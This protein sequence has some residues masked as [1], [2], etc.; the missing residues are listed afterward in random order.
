MLSPTL[1]LPFGTSSNLGNFRNSCLGWQIRNGNP[2]PLSIFKQ[3]SQKPMSRQK[4]QMLKSRKMENDFPQMPSH[5]N[6]PS[7]SSSFSPSPSP[8]SSLSFI[9]LSL[10]LSSS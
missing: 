7:S 10:S 5:V 2:S 6:Q 1:T 9:F 4:R 3:S 8:S